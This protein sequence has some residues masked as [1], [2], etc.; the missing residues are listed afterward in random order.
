MNLGLV[1]VPTQGLN[2]KQSEFNFTFN[3]DA[4]NARIIDTVSFKDNA[5]FSIILPPKVGFGVLLSRS[6]KLVTGVDFEYTKWSVSNYNTITGLNDVIAIRTGAEY[7]VKDN[8]FKVRVGFRYSKMP[9]VL[10]NKELDDMSISFGLALPFR[11]KDKL[12]VTEM[13]IGVE[14]GQRGKDDSGLLL[15]QYINVHNNSGN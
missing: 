7:T 6:N 4:G 12:N 1:L 10:N 9:I 8:R 11:S 14:L 5:S 3:G 13:N 15:E 2:A